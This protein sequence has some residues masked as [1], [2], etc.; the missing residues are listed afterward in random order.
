MSKVNEI[1]LS[2][3]AKINIC[4]GVT[5]RR[6][7]GYH[8]IDSVM[9][10]V[11][12]YDKVT[13]RAAECTRGQ[14]IS[15]I[16]P[17]YDSLNGEK[18]IAYRA[19]E[20]FMRRAA[21]DEYDIYIEINKIIPME[22]GLGG[23]SSDA[24]AV[25]LALNKLYAEPINAEELIALSA[26]V[27]A[28]VPFLVR[29]GTALVQGIGEI[30]TPCEALPDATVLLAYPNDEKVSTGKAYAAIDARGKFSSHEAFEAMKKAIS[31]KD[32]EQIGASAY[33]IFESVVPPS[34]VIFRIKETMIGYG[35]IFSLMSGSGSAVFGIY[36]DTESAQN[37]AQ[38]L[39]SCARVF[40]AGMHR[41]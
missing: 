38:A 17:G 4:L 40:V 23:G 10:T 26:S 5:G 33:N 35:A 7:D 36:R 32:I 6:A 34:S 25:F 24:A 2:A 22:A 9:Q 11:S 19:A 13:V 3:P 31:E 28:D 1:T 20:A 12:V 39:S 14:R 29:K 21:I 18:N 15:V 16:C 30:I 41:E 8:D 27:G 37:A